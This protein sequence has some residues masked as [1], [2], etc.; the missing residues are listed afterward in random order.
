MA[1]SG[2]DEELAEETP[3]WWADYIGTTRVLSRR[4]MA[5]L[6]PNGRTRVD[7]F[8]GYP[9]ILRVVFAGM[10]ADTGSTV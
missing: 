7:Y 9:K 8:L 10:I 3:E 1:A 2:P 6:F 5:E 4:R